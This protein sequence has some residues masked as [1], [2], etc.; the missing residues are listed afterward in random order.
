[1]TFRLKLL[2]AF[3]LI[4]MAATLLSAPL[5]RSATGDL[6]GPGPVEGWWGLGGYYG[7]DDTDR[8]EI[9]HRQ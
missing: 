3:S 5:A 8:G 9:V 7:N 6:G 4:L 1:M 2:A